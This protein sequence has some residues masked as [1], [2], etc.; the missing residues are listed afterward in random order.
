MMEAI[1]GLLSVVRI[2]FSISRFYNTS[3][4]ITSL[5]VKVTNQMI[6]SCRDYI[7]KN[8]PR[9]WEQDLPVVKGKFRLIYQLK[10][11]YQD[12][13]E[14]EKKRLLE[15]NTG[16]QFEVSETSIFGKFDM[17]C[18]RM[19]K[20]EE[21]MTSIERWSVL[22]NCKIDGIEFINVAFRDILSV[23]IK[24]PYDVFNT[25][26]ND[27]D[28]DNN[29][30]CQNLF[31]LLGSLNN[32]F[33]VSFAQHSQVLHALQYLAK[34]EKIKE[35][36]LD[37]SSKYKTC[38]SMFSQEI[39]QVR[40]NY[41]SVRSDPPLRRNLPPMAGRIIWARQLFARIEGPIVM[42]QAAIPSLLLSADAREVVNSYN[43][44]GRVL[45]EYELMFYDKF[46]FFIIHL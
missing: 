19:N 41:H 31:N 33:D 45:V 8:E 28:M 26:K 37:L 38:L 9:I 24:K 35:V 13:F 2:I 6:T 30:F 46:V 25:R 36:G 12:C 16:N 10:I 34:F 27:F 18:G 1:P 44:M 22:Q 17:F 32:F 43:K 39:E 40:K 42:F 11:L 7:Y 21:M 14:K 23:T 3:E 5:L 20:I 29:R 4:R 15:N